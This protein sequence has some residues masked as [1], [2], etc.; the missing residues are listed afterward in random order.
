MKL[1][2]RDNSALCSLSLLDTSSPT[3]RETAQH[4]RGQANRSNS[5]VISKPVVKKDQQEGGEQQ[6]F[7]TTLSKEVLEKD[8]T[9]V[10]YRINAQIFQKAKAIKLQLFWISTV[11]TRLTNVSKKH[12]KVTS[13]LD[14]VQMKIMLNTENFEREHKVKINESKNLKTDE[15]VQSKGHHIHDGGSKMK[16]N[17]LTNKISCDAVETRIINKQ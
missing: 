8:E 2:S 13:D 6:L 1:I 7:A 16:D 12:M 10:K 4:E 5:K 9:R 15:A 3:N 17:K 11:G 14:Q